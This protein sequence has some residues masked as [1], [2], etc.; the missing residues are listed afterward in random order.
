MLKDIHVTTALV[1]IIVFN[2]RW[3]GHIRQARF[4]ARRWVKIVPHV[5]DSVLLLTAI[6][7]AL[8]LGQYPFTANWLTAKLVALIGYILAGMM[9]LKWCQHLTGQIVSWLFA[10]ILFVYIISVAVT[11][12]PLGIVVFLPQFAL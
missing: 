2:I 4:M 8:G 5:N 7:L 9:A 10:Q 1:S 3:I 11:K 6:L 12:N